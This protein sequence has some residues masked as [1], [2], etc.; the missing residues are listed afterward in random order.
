MRLREYMI[1]VLGGESV[2]HRQLPLPE[3]Y[4]INEVIKVICCSFAS[5]MITFKVEN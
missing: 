1:I 2:S 5:K 4:H 3:V